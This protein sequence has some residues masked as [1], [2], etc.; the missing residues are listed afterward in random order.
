MRLGPSCLVA[1][2]RHCPR[3]RI[4]YPAAEEKDDEIQLVCSFCGL[5]DS[6][7]KRLI[8]GP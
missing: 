1:K 2:L 3:R 6:E 5:S 4:S 8:A 7:V